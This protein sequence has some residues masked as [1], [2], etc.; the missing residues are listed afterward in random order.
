MVIETFMQRIFKSSA[1]LFADIGAVDS[2]HALALKYD[3]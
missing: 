2:L 1:I 3:F